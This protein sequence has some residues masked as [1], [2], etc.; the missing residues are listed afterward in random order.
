VSALPVP[1][2]IQSFARRAIREN[3]VP[4]TIWLSQR[5]EMRAN[6]CDPWRPFGAEQ[7]IAIHKPGFAWLARVEVASLACGAHL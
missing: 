3:P 6:L 1:E 2:S 5:G 4:N 7:V